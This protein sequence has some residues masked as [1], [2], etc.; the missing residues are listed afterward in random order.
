[1]NIDE[2]K[3]VFLSESAFPTNKEWRKW[4]GKKLGYSP[5]T[6]G[7]AIQGFR[8]SEKLPKDF[9]Q[10]K[11][12]IQKQ[13]VVDKNKLTHKKKVGTGILNSKFLKCLTNHCNTMLDPTIGDYAFGPARIGGVEGSGKLSYIPPNSYLVKKIDDLAGCTKSKTNTKNSCI[14]DATFLVEFEPDSPEDEEDDETPPASQAKVVNVSFRATFT[15]GG[16]SASAQINQQ[17]QA[18]LS[19]F[20][21][22]VAILAVELLGIEYHSEFYPSPQII[23]QYLNFWGLVKT[24]DGLYIQIPKT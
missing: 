21:A 5:P 7:K 24:I 14:I 23:K 15:K 1:M 11:A 18:Y 4:A 20:P 10:R 6:M 8:R 3:S 22:N 9:K 12:D 13:Y 16:K 2:I 19:G 17:L